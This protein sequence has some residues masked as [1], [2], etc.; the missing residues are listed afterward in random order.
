MAIHSQPSFEPSLVSLM[1]GLIS[2]AKALLQQELLLAKHEMRDELN[3]TKQA[4]ISLGIG[5]AVGTLGVILLSFMLV[6]LLEA[7]TLIP[8]WGCYGIV[9]G[10][11]ALVG[12]VLLY[13][14][15]NI[16][17]DIDVVPQR[18]VETLKENAAWIK[19]RTTSASISEKPAH[20]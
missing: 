20:L 5:I 10:L 16:A 11:F 15:K 2:D 6:Y 14:G 3:K 8:L 12:G 13:V 9:G 18:T 19:E 17:A 4:V 1:S 7:L